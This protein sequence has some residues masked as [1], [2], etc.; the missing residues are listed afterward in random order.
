VPSIPV[1]GR[2]RQADPELK[3]SLVYRVSSRPLRETQRNPVSKTNKQTTK[4]QQNKLLH[5][6]VCVEIY[7]CLTDGN[8]FIMSKCVK[9]S[10]G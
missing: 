6:S 8:A 5:S 7:M 9:R 3:A 4:Q 2:Q 10:S 1:L